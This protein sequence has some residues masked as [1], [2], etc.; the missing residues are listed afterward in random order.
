MSA[1]RP[2]LTAALCISRSWTRSKKNSGRSTSWWPASLAIFM[3]KRCVGVRMP[4]PR[5]SHDIYECPS[6][7]RDNESAHAPISWAPG[8]VVPLPR[9]VP[10]AARRQRPLYYGAPGAT[11]PPPRPADAKGRSLPA[12]FHA[13]VHVAGWWRCR[14]PAAPARSQPLFAPSRSPRTKR[15][16]SPGLG[17][18]SLEPL[19]P[20]RGAHR[21]LVVETGRRR[22]LVEEWWV[23]ELGKRGI[24]RKVHLRA[25]WRSARSYLRLKARQHRL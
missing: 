21:A 3:P 6:D 11:P 17:R 4:A 2:G 16:R 5:L 1:G 19:L 25:T 7:G 20:D 9:R 15:R 23:I 8:G 22:G 14:Q 18:H 10:H 12:A 13:R 24:Q